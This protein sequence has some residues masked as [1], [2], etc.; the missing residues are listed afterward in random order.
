MLLCKGLPAPGARPVE[1]AYRPPS[2]FDTQPTR[3]ITSL[4]PPHSY[5]AG[6]ELLEVT[7]T[8]LRLRKRTLE[9]GMRRQ[10]KRRDDSMA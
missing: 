2:H 5:V 8:K 10:Q 7:P 1:N 3:R 6:D 9:S 4:P